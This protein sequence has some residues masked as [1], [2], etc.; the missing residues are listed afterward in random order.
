MFRPTAKNLKQVTQTTAR[1]QGTPALDSSDHRLNQR[2]DAD[3][4]SPYNLSHHVK[5]GQ[6][7]G[8]YGILSLS[9]AGHAEAETTSIKKRASHKNDPK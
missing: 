1:N 7:E 9:A 2:Q 3:A 6:H 5:H 8:Q 4:S